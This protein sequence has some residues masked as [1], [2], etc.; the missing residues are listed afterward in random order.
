MLERNVG[1]AT[2]RLSEFYDRHTRSLDFYRDAP[3]LGVAPDDFGRA[4]D[5]VAV[6]A[7]IY[8]SL[9]RPPQ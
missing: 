8:E 4:A 3:L 7:H 1:A 5:N 6:L 2:E 9:L